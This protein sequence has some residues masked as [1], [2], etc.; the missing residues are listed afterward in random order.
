MR[1]AGIPPTLRSR[2]P[3]ERLPV[4]C[5]SLR[6]SAAMSIPRE[7][8]RRCR[9]DSHNAICKQD[10]RADA[11][12]TIARSC[13]S[14]PEEFDNAVES[15]HYGLGEYDA[16]QNGM[17]QF[18]RP[19]GSGR[20]YRDSAGDLWTYDRSLWTSEVDAPCR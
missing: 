6:S 8:S 7:D 5:A 16:Y 20:R 9:T 13:S 17:Q 12:A 14:G 1:S 15:I 11:A 19:R 18:A 4:F 2:R 10:L 3:H